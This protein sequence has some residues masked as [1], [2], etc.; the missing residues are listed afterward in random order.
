MAAPRG[1][2][3]ALLA[4]YGIACRALG[5]RERRQGGGGPGRVGVPVAV[6]L[7]AR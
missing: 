3:Q 2:A 1:G 5:S 4:A 6:K 7:A